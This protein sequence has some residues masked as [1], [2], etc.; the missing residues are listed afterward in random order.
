MNDALRCLR[1]P[2]RC[3]ERGVSD[4][5]VRAGSAL[6]GPLCVSDHG[7]VRAALS[8]LPW[9]R[10]ELALALREPAAGGDGGTTRVHPDIPLRED[11]DALIRE[12]DRAVFSWSTALADELGL[13]ELN[14]FAPS[15]RRIA[16]HLDTL[17]VLGP[18]R[19][20][21]W[22]N[23]SAVPLLPLDTPGTVRAS[24][25]ARIVREMTGGQ[26]ALELLRLHTR[27]CALIRRDT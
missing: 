17:Y 4:G 8:D 2:V 14:R 27:G 10:L 1:G 11:V 7:K 18:T 9:L 3:A 13:A 15:A 6:Y 23:A 22:V 16:V 12:L 20:S 5:A 24:G 21:R 25:E 19:V 26:G